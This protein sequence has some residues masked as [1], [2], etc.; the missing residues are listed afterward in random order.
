[1]KLYTQAGAVAK[2][3]IA[4]LLIGLLAILQVQIWTGRG[5]IPSVRQMEKKLSDLQQQNQAAQLENDGLAAE[6]GHGQAQRNLR[7]D[8]PVTGGPQGPLCF[9]CHLRR[10][11]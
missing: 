10:H 8:Q 11:H 1:M 9:A 2:R 5:S 3:V 4:G 6:V 7:A